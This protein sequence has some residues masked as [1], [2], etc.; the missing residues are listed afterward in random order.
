MNRN[1]SD[2]D[3]SIINYNN[4]TDGSE[5]DSSV[6]DLVSN[7]NGV[8]AF[9]PTRQQSNIGNIQINSSNDITVGNRIIYQGPV[10]IQQQIVNQHR[11]DQRAAGN[12]I[13]R[14]ANILSR[15]GK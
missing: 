2:R 8:A 7:A 15:P 9:E 1:S 10:T 13:N 4:L 11:A 14:S 5:S 12:N 6:T 3:L